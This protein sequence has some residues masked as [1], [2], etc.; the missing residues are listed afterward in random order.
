MIY[1]TDPDFKREPS[2]NS[3]A[4]F[5]ALNDEKMIYAT[6]DGL[7]IMELDTK[8]TW[9][10]MHMDVVGEV[11]EVFMTKSWIVTF[12]DDIFNIWDINNLSLHATIG[13]DFQSFSYLYYKK[14]GRKYGR[15]YDDYFGD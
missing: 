11:R 6:D 9:Q 13:K 7:K 8:Q 3:S 15:D 1:A 4:G 10:H 5:A 14:R 12:N 2:L